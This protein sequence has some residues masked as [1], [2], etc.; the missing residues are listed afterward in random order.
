[1]TLFSLLPF[2]TLGSL[3]RLG[4]KASQGVLPDFGGEVEV[5]RDQFGN[6]LAS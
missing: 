5:L 6:L 3:E 2:E 1:M 4:E